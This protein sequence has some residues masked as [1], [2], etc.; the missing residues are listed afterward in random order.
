MNVLLVEPLNTDALIR[1]ANACRSMKLQPFLLTA[2]KQKF[3]E[4]FP[5]FEHVFEID[6][7][8]QDGSEISDTLSNLCFKGV[9]PCS[10][11]SVEISDNLAARLSLPHNNLEKLE[12]MRDK[13]TMRKNFSLAGIPQPK[14]YAHIKN[15]DGLE[16]LTQANTHLKFPVIV[17][18]VDLASSTLVKQCFDWLEIRS[19]IEKIL[20]YRRSIYTNINFRGQALVEEFIEG[21]EFSIEGIIDNN[22]VAFYSITKKV[23]SPLPYCDE[24]GQIVGLPYSDKFHAAAVILLTNVAQS[25]KM[26]AGCIHA[27]FKLGQQG[28]QLIEAAARI[29]GDFIADLIELRWGVSLESALIAA[30]CSILEEKA[31]KTSSARQ[32]IVGIRHLF[33][34]NLQPLLPKKAKVIRERRENKESKNEIPYSVANRVG[35]I[36]IG[37]DKMSL[38]CKKFFGLNSIE[39]P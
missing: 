25:W 37:F 2:T 23:V 11:F 34:D 17:K 8:S 22:K 15:H 30:R 21:P 31:Y 19:Q 35:F 26:T 13:H 20:D 9:I 14:I 32:R 27:E 28:L 29:P 12:S 24:V 6:S 1:F 7:L 39:I 4:Y 38:D 10:E 36:I 16:K 33:S 18:P 3:A 5:L